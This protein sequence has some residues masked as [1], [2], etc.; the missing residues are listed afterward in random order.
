MDSRSL[1]TEKFH[2]PQGLRGAG[3]EPKEKQGA[4][5]N[6]REGLTEK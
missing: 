3:K 1:A 2:P 6:G 5:A 4:W